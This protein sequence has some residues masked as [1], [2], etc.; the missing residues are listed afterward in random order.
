MDT[1]GG[2]VIRPPKRIYDPT[3]WPLQHFVHVQDDGDGRGLAILQAM[4]GAVSYQADGTLE[5]I[6]MRNA[7]RERAFGLINLPANPASG[8]ERT[9]YAFDYALLFTPSGDWRDNDIPLAAQSLISSPWDDAERAALHNLADSIVTTDCPDVRVMAVKPATR[10]EG[11]GI[12]RLYTHA[13]PESPVMVT[14]HHF[15]VTGA[16]L[17]DARERDLGPLEVQDSTVRVAMPGTIA[18]IRLL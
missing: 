18:T 5:L 15:T 2:I 13:L 9:S 16:F 17:C 14:A 8:H 7:T 6:A 12:V 1:P 3:F 4:P 10:G 11:G